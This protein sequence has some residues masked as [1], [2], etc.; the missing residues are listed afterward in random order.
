MRITLAEIFG[1]KIR[2]Y[3]LMIAIGIIAASA[4][5]I[6]QAKKKGY[7]ED[8]VLNMI[9]LTVLGGILGGKVL[10][11]ITEIKDIIKKPSI[12]KDFGYGFVVYGAIIGGA[13]TIYLYCKKKKWNV[14]ELLDSTVP[15]LAIAQGFGRIGCLMAGCCYGA[16]TDSP[17]SIVFPEGSLAPSGVHLHPTQIYSSIFDFLLGIFLLWYIKKSNKSGKVVG[18]YFI[19]YSIGRFL[20]EFLRNDP[21]GNVGVLST[22]QFIAIFTLIVGIVFFN[23]HKFFKG[24][25]GSCERD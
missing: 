13:L 8:S 11:I 21:R 7:D 23:I 17:I 20:I 16:E 5:L 18:A 9:I 3:G 1:I 22:S 19:A 6:K 4:L 2:S 14:L 24:V 10:F 15:G 12:L 25:N